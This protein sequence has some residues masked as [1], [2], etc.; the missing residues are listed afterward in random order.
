MPTRI[1]IAEHCSGSLP[2]DLD[3]RG[4]V[5]LLGETCGYVA[6]KEKPLSSLAGG[7]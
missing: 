2:A 5:I 4:L 3:C 1:V 6:I 7:A